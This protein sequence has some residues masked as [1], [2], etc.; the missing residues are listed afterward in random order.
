VPI[1]RLD[2]G[3]EG[4][5]LSSAA[6][7]LVI[8]PA[9]PDDRALVVLLARPQLARAEAAADAIRGLIGTAESSESDPD[10]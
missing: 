10:Q 7:A 5:L 2:Y 8:T 6:G 3:L 4:P 9:D 1:C